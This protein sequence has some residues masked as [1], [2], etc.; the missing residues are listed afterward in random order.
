MP[1]VELLVRNR[2]LTIPG[3]TARFVAANAWEISVPRDD[4]TARLS[5]R[6][7]DPEAWDTAVFSLDGVQAHE[8]VGS[9][10]TATQPISSS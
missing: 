4:T 7:L 6:T 3:T 2:F 8:A 10:I 1:A 9:G 5:R